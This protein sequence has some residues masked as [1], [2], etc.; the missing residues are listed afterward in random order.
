MTFNGCICSGYCGIAP[1]GHH[2][3]WDDNIYPVITSD[4]GNVIH[5]S[6]CGEPA[7]TCD[8]WAFELMAHCENCAWVMEDI[9]PKSR[10]KRRWGETLEDDTAPKEGN[11]APS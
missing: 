8:F 6:Y 11:N 5:C 1:Q 10:R 9:F 7:I 2:F 3:G 4:P